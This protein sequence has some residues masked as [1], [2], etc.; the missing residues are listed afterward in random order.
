MEKIMGKNFVIIV[1]IAI[2]GY[3]GYQYIST[4]TYDQIVVF[5]GNG[6]KP[7]DYAKKALDKHDAE[8]IEYNI[9]ESAENMKLFKKHKG[10]T[11][12]LILIGDQRLDEFDPTLLEVVLNGYLYEIDSGNNEVMMYVIKGCGWCKK[13]SNFLEKNGIPFKECDI[14]ESESCRNEYERLRGN[15]TPLIIVGS[16]KVYGFHEKALTLALKQ[17]KLM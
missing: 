17:V 15:G 16:N 12:P 2:A 11:I 13:A 9:G 5:T 3:F 7:C 8:Y 10:K 6:C 4:P 14:R 1:I